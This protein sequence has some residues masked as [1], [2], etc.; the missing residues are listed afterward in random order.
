MSPFRKPHLQKKVANAASS[1][2]AVA[3][4]MTSC[5]TQAGFVYRG[6][7]EE[8]LEEGDGGGE[9]RP[10]EGGGGNFRINGGKNI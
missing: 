1:Q 9:G 6:R 5:E 3:K 10:G 8:C 4:V 7:L 2:S